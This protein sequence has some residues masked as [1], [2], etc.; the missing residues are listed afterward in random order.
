LEVWLKGLNTS[1]CIVVF[2]GGALTKG[3]PTGSLVRVTLYIDRELWKKLKYLSVDEGKPL[4]EIL[5][6]AVAEK[7]E[8]MGRL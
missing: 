2:G 5:R 6:E 4:A 7:L 1:R 3:K 8:R